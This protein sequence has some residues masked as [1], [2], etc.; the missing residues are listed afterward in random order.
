MTLERVHVIRDSCN[1]Q[2]SDLS[3][4]VRKNKF[5]AY[6]YISFNQNLDGKI[7]LSA[8]IKSVKNLYAVFFCLQRKS[9][10][11][12]MMSPTSNH[13]VDSHD[14]FDFISSTVSSC[15]LMFYWNVN[16]IMNT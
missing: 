7:F 2:A 15:G 5:I 9:V 6:I 8:K 14:H 1:L 4:N 3:I 11:N 16:Y 12:V 10:K 13:I